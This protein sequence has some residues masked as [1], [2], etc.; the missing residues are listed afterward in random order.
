MSR[1][2]TSGSFAPGPD[3]RRNLAGRPKGILEI[4]AALRRISHEEIEIDGVTLPRME[5]LLRAL[6][7]RALKLDYRAV[8]LILGYCA[9]TVAEV[10]R[11]ITA[12]AYGAVMDGILEGYTVEDLRLMSDEA[13]RHIE[14]TLTAAKERKANDAA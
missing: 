11:E 14:E 9:G 13:G 1:P 4:P 7:E 3:A 8:T 2:P 5:H 12:E 6:F 10:K